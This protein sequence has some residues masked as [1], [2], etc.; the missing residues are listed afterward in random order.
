MAPLNVG[1][2]T[3]SNE[4]IDLDLVDEVISRI[5][6]KSW[7]LIISRLVS[8]LVDMMPSNVLTQ[9]TGDS[10]GYDRAE[11]ILTS[12]YEENP[13][14]ELIEDCFKILGT[15]Q[16]LYRLDLLQLEQFTDEIKPD[17]IQV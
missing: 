10:E 8:E 4:L 11:A 14:N 6:D 17:T 9:L 15:E 16:T 7:G 12:Y 1:L 3:M 13:S 5:P 2:S